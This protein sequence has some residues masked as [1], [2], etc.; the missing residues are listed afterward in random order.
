MS[1]S[2]AIPLPPVPPIQVGSYGKGGGYKFSED[3][4]DSVI[5]QWEDLLDDLKNDLDSAERIA[6]VQAPGDEPASN[7]Y[8]KQGAGPSGESLKQQHKAMVDYT[9]NFITAL[10]A[11]KNKITVAEQQAADAAKAPAKGQGV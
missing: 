2:G 8:V 5:K 4:I 10:R 7:L 3:E 9:V 11:A 6:N 1:D